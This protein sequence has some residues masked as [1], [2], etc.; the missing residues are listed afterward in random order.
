MWLAISSTSKVPLLEI[1]ST[2]NTDIHLE[3]ILKKNVKRRKNQRTKT[4]EK[5]GRRVEE[6]QCGGLFLSVTLD[7]MIEEL[8]FR[9]VSGLKSIFIQMFMSVFK[10]GTSPHYM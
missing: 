2:E 8:V 4:G 3:S 6:T 9:T 1:W 7:K 10:K 5:V